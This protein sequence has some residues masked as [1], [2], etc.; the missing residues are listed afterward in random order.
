MRLKILLLAATCLLAGTAQAATPPVQKVQLK[1]SQIGFTFKQEAVPMQGGFSRYSGELVLDEKNAAASSVQMRI[2][3][4]SINA[5][6]G[7]ADTY[8][9]LP[10][11]FNVAQFPQATFTSKSMKLLGPGR[12]EASGPLMIKGT[13]RPA[14]V[15]FTAKVL[16]DGNT[17]LTG[18]F[19]IKRND[20]GVGEGEW[21]AVD[22][23]ANEVVVKFRVLFAK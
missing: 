14:V 5:G 4:G 2:D 12:W 17:E 21:S 22:V 7:E 3:T 18:T 20:Y 9:V 16:A 6:G 11:W 1:G 15:P 13:S 19:V 23:V 8:V 10:E